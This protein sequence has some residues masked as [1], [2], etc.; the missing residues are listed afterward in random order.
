MIPPPAPSTLLGAARQAAAAEPV[1]EP[2]ARLSAGA[3]EVRERLG[4]GEPVVLLDVRDAAEVARDGIAGAVA[5]PIDEL[6]ARWEELRYRDEVVCVSNRGERS[7][8]A[9]RL[10]REKG[11]FNATSLDGGLEAWIAAERPT[12]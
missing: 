5:I 3:Q 11:L 12:R 8:R 9:A 4:A 7:L 10:L 6:P 1:A 2:L